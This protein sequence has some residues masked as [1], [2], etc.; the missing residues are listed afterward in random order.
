MIEPDSVDNAL[1][2]AEDACARVLCEMLGLTPEVDFTVSTSKGYPDCA[3]FDIGRLQSGDVAAFPSN[4][5]HFRAHADLYNRDRATLQCWIMRILDRMHIGKNWFADHPLR[6]DTN[7]ANFQVAPEANAVGEITT[8]TVSTSTN[9][10]P[11]PTY[12]VTVAFDVV[13]VSRGSGEGNTDNDAP[14]DAPPADGG[15]GGTD[16]PPPDMGSTDGN[17]SEIDK[18]G[19]S[20]GGNGDEID[21]PGG[22]TGGSGAI[23]S[24]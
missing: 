20:T 17:G 1:T 24:M 5:W 21:T 11:V 18:P 12:T 23:P 2:Q 3:V 6:E 16:T 13:F 14:P 22:D 7:V 4:A 15:E 9:A 8:T 10:Q 19:G